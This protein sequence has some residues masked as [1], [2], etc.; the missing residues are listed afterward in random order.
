MDL[1]IKHRELVRK[2]LTLN[3]RSQYKYFIAVLNLKSFGLLLLLCAIVN[4][5]QANFEFG[6]FSGLVTHVCGFMLIAG[7]MSISPIAPI[8][9][10]ETSNGFNTLG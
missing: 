2:K 3:L 1:F 8:V 5:Q 9:I 10:R 7:A 4:T 6:S